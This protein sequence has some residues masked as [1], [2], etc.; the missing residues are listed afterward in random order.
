MAKTDTYNGVK[1]V[2][3][4]PAKIKAAQQITNY[5]STG[6][7]YSR[8]RYGEDNSKWGERPCRDCGVIK[9]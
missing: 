4:W 7:K 1:M 6:R 9:G 5:T 8:I 3:D 2:A